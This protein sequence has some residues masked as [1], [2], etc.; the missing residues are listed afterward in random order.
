MLVWFVLLAWRPCIDSASRITKVRYNNE[1]L[2][3]FWSVSWLMR[4]RKSLSWKWVCWSLVICGCK[5]EMFYDRTGETFNPLWCIVIS[6]L[7]TKMK[8][9]GVWSFQFFLVSVLITRRFLVQIERIL[10]ENLRTMDRSVVYQNVSSLT[11]MAGWVKM[12]ADPW[13]AQFVHHQYQ[14]L[15]ERHYKAHNCKI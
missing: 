13:P 3:I 10:I 12:V 9:Y 1:I 7:L 2:K 6:M 5:I 15:Y 8:I 14:C 4:F 11:W